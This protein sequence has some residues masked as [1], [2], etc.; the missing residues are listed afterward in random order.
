MKVKGN[1][2]QFPRRRGSEDDARELYRAAGYKLMNSIANLV[3]L[4]MLNVL[5]GIRTEK[6]SVRNHTSSV[7]ALREAFAHDPW[8]HAY[9]LLLLCPSKR[10]RM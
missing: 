7:C 5:H 9:I 3:F 8:L 1:A 4:R 10:L 2:R 6:V